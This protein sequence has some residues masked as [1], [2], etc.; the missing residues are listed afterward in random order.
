MNS[1]IKTRWL[2]ALRSGQYGQGRNGYLRQGN[3]FCCLGVLC[4][5]AVQDGLAS[6]GDMPDTDEHD[7]H[8]IL[9]WDGRTVEESEGNYDYLPGEVQRWAGLP[10]RDP[11]VA[12]EYMPYQLSDLNDNQNKNFSKIA[13]YIEEASF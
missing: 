1:E 13:D 12:I 4:D 6:W 3:L 8:Q 10:D 2:A 7:A 9:V 11:S 5:L